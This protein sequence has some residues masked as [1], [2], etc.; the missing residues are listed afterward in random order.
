MA[1]DGLLN[2][3]DFNYP[4]RE[5]C[6]KGAEGMRRAMAE[7]RGTWQHTATRCLD[8]MTPFLRAIKENTPLPFPY[9]TFHDMRQWVQEGKAGLAARY[10][11][12]T[13]SAPYFSGVG[14]R[15][16]YVPHA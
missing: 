13:A 12:L 10:C 11:L 9:V 15:L 5:A 16:D 1:G 14:R 3:V 8:Q 6:V 7:R 2:V 4:H